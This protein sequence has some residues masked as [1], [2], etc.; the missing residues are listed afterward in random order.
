M[1]HDEFWKAIYFGVKGGQGHETQTVCRR[2][3]LHS[4]ECWLLLAAAAAASVDRR[5]CIAASDITGRR[6]QFPPVDRRLVQSLSLPLCTCV[7]PP[8]RRHGGRYNVNFRSSSTACNRVH[9]DPVSL[10]GLRRAKP[11]RRPRPHTRRR[12]PTSSFSITA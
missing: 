5:T 4:C 9:F 11:S 3:S 12:R 10:L 8:A 1:S 2:G 7:G 6:R